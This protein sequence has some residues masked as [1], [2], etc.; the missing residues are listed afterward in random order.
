MKKILVLAFVL[1]FASVA[2]SFANTGA[3]TTAD[4]GKSLFAGVAAAA[5]G[6]SDG[7]LVGKLSKGVYA[8]WSTDSNGYILTTQHMSGNRSFG[9]SHDATA[10]F[11][12]DSSVMD[13]S[14]ATGANLTQDY[15]GSG[16]WTA[17]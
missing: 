1:I 3:P 11:R 12:N 13:P 10:I 15:F 4:E 5:T 14:S 8:G 7:T 16:N 17:M 6:S 9:S 2:A